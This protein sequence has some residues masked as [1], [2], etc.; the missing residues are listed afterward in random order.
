MASHNVGVPYTALRAERSFLYDTDTFPLD[1]LLAGI[2]GVENLSLIHEDSIKDKRMLLSPMLD[3]A[4]REPFHACYQSF[5]TTFA[6][7]LL[8]SIA[9]S[10]NVFLPATSGGET[11]SSITY[12]FQQFPCIRI[13]RP[14]EFSIGPHSDISYGHSIGTIVRM[15]VVVPFLFLNIYQPTEP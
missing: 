10:Q 3:E 4:N 15:R 7:P 11:S 5:V 13:V 12:R 14:G 9:L 6:I 8:H 1:R 2:I